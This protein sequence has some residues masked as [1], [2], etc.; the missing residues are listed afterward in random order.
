VLRI[1]SSID[2]ENDDPV[3]CYGESL[4]ICEMLLQMIESEH[5]SFDSY[6]SVEI[7]GETM[8]Q[9]EDEEPKMWDEVCFPCLHWSGGSWGAMCDVA[10]LFSQY[11]KDY[12]KGG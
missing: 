10:H 7:N 8:Y 1:D 5:D 11:K 2:I 4:D 12:L 6:K 3:D 9:Y